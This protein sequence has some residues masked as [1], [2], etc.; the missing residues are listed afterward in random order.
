MCAAHCRG[1]D[2]RQHRLTGRDLA[3]ERVRAGLRQADVAAAAGFSRGRASQ[4]EALRLVT[5]AA[6]ERYLDAIR[7]TRRERFG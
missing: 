5:D 2:P 6:A 1:M 4:L 7:A 3:A